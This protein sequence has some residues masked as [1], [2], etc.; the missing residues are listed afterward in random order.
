[1]PDPEVL[2]EGFEDEFN[3][4]LDLVNSG[5]IFDEPLVLHDRYQEARCKALTKSGEQCKK[6]AMAGL[7]YC[8]VHKAGAE[9]GVQ[10]HIGKDLRSED[11]RQCSKQAAHGSGYCSIHRPK[12]PEKDSRAK[13]LAEILRELKKL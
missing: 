3:Y 7:G 11:G 13:D 5:K 10:A 1:M 8:N 9:K 4:L 6:R 2:L 12:M